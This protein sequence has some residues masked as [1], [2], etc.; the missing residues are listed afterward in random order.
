MEDTPGTLVVFLVVVPLAALLAGA[1]LRWTPRDHLLVVA[2]RG[3]VRRVVGG[4]P[5]WRVPFLDTVTAEPLEPEPVT[6]SVRATTRDGHRVRLLAEAPL[7]VVPPQPGEPAGAADRARE[8]AEDRLAEELRSTVEARDL[9]DLDEL[10]V[11]G[12]AVVELDVV[13]R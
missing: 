5:T 3:T 8:A 2:R 9:G 4:G 13:L 10:E 1:S 11:H 7:P 6:V 12:L